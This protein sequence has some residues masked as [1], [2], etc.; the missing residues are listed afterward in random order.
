MHNQGGINGNGLQ[1]RHEAYH[2]VDGY[3]R[4][5]SYVGNGNAD[6]TFVYCGF[7]PA[8]VMTK[9]INS[10]SDWRVWDTARNTYNTTGAAMGGSMASIKLSD[11]HVEDTSIGMDI[12]SNGFKP[13]SSNSEF[14]T[15]NGYYLYYAIAETPFKNANAR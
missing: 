11:N 1:M 12:L 10:T 14:N 15:G 13:R 6:G 3:S 8:Y 4:I 7:R 9:R 2:S 5:G